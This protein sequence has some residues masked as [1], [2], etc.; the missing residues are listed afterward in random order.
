MLPSPCTR[1]CCL[2]LQDIC[3]GCGRSLDEI[4]AWSNADEQRQQQILDSAS[5]RQQQRKQQLRHDPASL[6]G[7]PGL[8]ARSDD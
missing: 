2:D 3:L 1:I 8:N 5:L 6:F 4:K 7:S